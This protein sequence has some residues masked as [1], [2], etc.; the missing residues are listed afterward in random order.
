LSDKAIDHAETESGALADLLGCE[1]GLKNPIP[2]FGR[3]PAAGVRDGH[4]YI[5]SGQAPGH[6]SFIQHDVLRLDLEYA[7]VGHGIAPVQGQVEES[8]LQQ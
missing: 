2:Y 5:R 4:L 7:A 3:H 1:E 8:G 6:G